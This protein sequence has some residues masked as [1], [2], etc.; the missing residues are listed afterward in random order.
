[1]LLI[2]VQQLVR[3]FKAEMEELRSFTALR[4][5]VCVQAE[6]LLCFSYRIPPG[7][8]DIYSLQAVAPEQYEEFEFLKQTV[9][10]LDNL[11]NAR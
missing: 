10:M 7:R 9:N 3:S 6:W 11:A 2:L 5:N 8:D 1:M 4:S